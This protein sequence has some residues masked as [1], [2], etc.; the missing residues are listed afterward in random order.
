MRGILHDAAMSKGVVVAVGDPLV[1][2]EV[3]HAVAATGHAIVDVKEPAQLARLAGRARAVVVDKLMAQQLEQQLDHPAVVFVAGDP[4]PIDWQA[5]LRAGAREAVVVPA[6]AAELLRMLGRSEAP[7]PHG[8][9]SIGV[10][11]AVGGSGVSVFAAALAKENDAATVLIDATMNSGGL[12]LLLGTEGHRGARWNDLN[13]AGGKVNASDLL[14]ALPGDQRVKVL[15]VQRSKGALVAPDANSVCGALDTLQG[16]DVV[17]DLSIALPG[18]MEVVAALESLAIVIPAELRA[19]S[20]AAGLVARVRSEARDTA[21]L[22]VVRH[23]SW[24]GLSA[25]EIA[26]IVDLEVVAEVPTQRGIAKQLDMTGLGKV[27]RSLRGPARL[28]LAESRRAH[29]SH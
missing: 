22:G 29:G 25:E 24:S 9:L 6:Q 11:G 20:A 5:A 1:H 7:E 17:V 12:D 14:A 4:G 15:T 26:S 21:L 16:H 13:L 18:F 2:P 10:L 8:A 27:P 28:V 3:M 23:R 19:V